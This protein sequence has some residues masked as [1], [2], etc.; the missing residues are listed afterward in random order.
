[1]TRRRKKKR[2]RGSLFDS[3]L[4]GVAET[5][6]G[7]ANRIDKRL[8]ERAGEV[9]RQVVGEVESYIAGELDDSDWQR[10]ALLQKVPNKDL[11][12]Y[13]DQM[14]HLPEMREVELRFT[15]G[16]RRYSRLELEHEAHRRG[17]IKPT[18]N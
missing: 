17:L 2:E 1:M 16:V 5:L 8:E 10:A 18:I 15:S 3:I 6:D 7:A 14:K 11:A 4:E 12:S 13:I 9:V